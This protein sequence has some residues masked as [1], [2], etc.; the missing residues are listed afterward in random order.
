MV[1][2]GTLTRGAL[3]GAAFMTLLFGH[4]LHRG[5][6][7]A[8]A[9]NIGQLEPRP[10]LFNQ[11]PLARS[12]PRV[13][14]QV[15]LGPIKPT[16]KIPGLFWFRSSPTEKKKTVY[17]LDIVANELT[18]RTTIIAFWKEAFVGQ[19]NDECK[20]DAI[21]AAVN[22]TTFLLEDMAYDGVGTVLSDGTNATG[23][24]PSRTGSAYDGHD[25]TVVPTLTFDMNINFC[26]QITHCKGTHYGATRGS[27]GS[28]AGRPAAVQL[29]PGSRGSAVALAGLRS[30]RPDAMP[31][32]VESVLYYE[33]MGYKH[34]YI[35]VNGLPGCQ[36]QRDL[37]ENLSRFIAS[38]FASIHPCGNGDIAQKK[39]KIPFLN[40]VL[41]DVKGRYDWLGVWDPDEI[42]V[43]RNFNGTH[44][45]D[46]VMKELVG[47]RQVDGAD[48]PCFVIFRSTS[49]TVNLPYGTYNGEI[50]PRRLE[51]FGGKASYEKSMVNPNVAMFT[52]LHYPGSCSLDQ[53][54]T[55]RHKP[56]IPEDF[57]KIENQS[58]AGINH[59][60]NMFGGRYGN[61]ADDPRV[62]DEYATYF[63]PF[64]KFLNRTITGT[65][66]RR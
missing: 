47:E 1:G 28:L 14:D 50:Y 31:K 62:A 30:I 46:A 61:K 39:A 13:Q 41:Y 10:A 56:R 53:W 42:M 35:G 38:G 26:I 25:C 20:Q 59:Y 52:G 34:V 3:F 4:M 12:A 64:L 11:R 24:T 48:P 32:M 43:P 17:V 63:Y 19:G 21:A 8:H 6:Q 55:T 40:A 22:E 18:N 29:A 2:N 44:N 27:L 51:A 57:V 36:T 16:D 15:A 5:Q 37:E 49:L 65:L 9:P 60:A 58:L 66:G 23:L 7:G 54:T 45:V 33:H